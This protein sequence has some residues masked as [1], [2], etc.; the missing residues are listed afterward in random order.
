MRAEKNTRTRAAI[1]A[2]VSTRDQN[3]SMQLQALREYAARRGLEVVG[4]F[5]DVGVSGAKDTR[6]ELTKLM[7]AARKRKLE[8]VLVY[9][10]DRFARSVKHLVVALE[11]FQSLGIEFISYSENID[12]GTPLGRALFT[13]A[14]ALGEL[15]RNLIVE[16]SMEGQRR[17]KERGVKLGRPCVKVDEESVRR[18][19]AHGLS[20]RRICA[21]LH[22]S[23]GVVSRTLARSKIA[24]QNAPRGSRAPA[25]RGRTRRRPRGR[26]AAR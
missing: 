16:R 2:R 19:K 7:D 4:E 10:F 11:E 8:V 26:S 21:E 13:I 24:A 9:R 12:T 20:H 22:L 5:V 14:G 18:L 15:E 17:A 1:Y 23:M 25:C 6:P 3:V